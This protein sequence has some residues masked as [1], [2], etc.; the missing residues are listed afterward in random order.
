MIKGGDDNMGQK[1]LNK[2]TNNPFLS[3]KP[4]CLIFLCSL[5][6]YLTV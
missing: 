5:E 1:A 2:L 6:K 3:S 4:L